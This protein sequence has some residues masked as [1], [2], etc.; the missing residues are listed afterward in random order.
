MKGESADEFSGLSRTNE[1]GFVI[2]STSDEADGDS[3]P[4]V[5]ETRARITSKRGQAYCSKDHEGLAN[6]RLIAAAPALLAALES[7]MH[8]AAWMDVPSAVLDDAKAA[9]AAARGEEGGSK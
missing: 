4:A 8:H 2:Y 7:L 6:A 3:G 1:G 5:A 9:I